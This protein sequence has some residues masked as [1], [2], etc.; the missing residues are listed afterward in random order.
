VH[1][2]RAQAARRPHHPALAFGESRLSYGEL[3]LAIDRAASWLERRG[4]QRG[5]AI[6]LVGRNSLDYVVLLLAAARIGVRVALP[7]P[8]LEASALVR[9]V[10]QA[11]CRLLLCEAQWVERAAKTSPV[12]VLGYSGDEFST[13][14]QHGDSTPKSPLPAGGGEDFAYVY[15][16]GTTGISKPCRVSHRRAVLAAVAFGHLV[17]GLKPSDVVYCAL[18]LYHSTALLLGLGACLGAGATLALRERFS[19]SAL[20]GDVRRYDASVLLYVGD[21]VRAL[22]A[23]PPS[24][25]DRHHRLRLAL[26]NG[27]A[28]ECWGPLKAR[29]GVARIAEFYAASEFP[30]AIVNL[31]GR[32]GS[33]GRLPFG[34]FRGYR[35]VQVDVTSGELIRDSAGRAVECGDGEPGELV[36]R[37]SA[38]P[39][40]PTGD[41]LGYLNQGAGNERVARDLFEAGDTYCRSGDLLRRDDSGHYFFVD[42]L[43]DTFR[44]KGENVSTREVESAFVGVPGVV[45]LLSLGVKL[46]NYDGKLGLLVVEA[47]AE[48][49]MRVLAERANGL[50]PKARPCFLRLVSQLE[51]TDSFKIKKAGFAEDGVDPSRIRDRLFYRSGDGYLPLGA[52]EY[53]RILA[54]QLRF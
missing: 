38:H 19:A 33:V 42:R 20:L 48:L 41:Y 24:A 26:G 46:P 34:R 11:S 36:L 8:E 17:H 10:E 3:T 18:P 44:F 54:S 7:S 30:G 4:L 32:A 1:L 53:E 12:P 52:A 14:V 9:A 47:E 29:F 49:D 23:Q 39:E 45:A 16:S 35:L 27:L 5:E 21:L 25:E 51:R 22:V 37:L 15:T 31:S 28:V 13:P 50:V 43:G 6:A 2:A 40:R